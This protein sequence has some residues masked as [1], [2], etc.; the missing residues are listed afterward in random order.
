M[1]NG[2]SIR[3]REVH[4]SAGVRSDTPDLGYRN[5]G[6]GPRPRPGSIHDSEDSNTVEHAD[7]KK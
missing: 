2:R 6:P 4:A 3:S 7:G 1:G 5:G